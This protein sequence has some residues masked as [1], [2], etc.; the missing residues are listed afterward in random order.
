[1]LSKEELKNVPKSTQQA[2]RQR[3][4]SKSIRSEYSYY[5]E[6]KELIEAFLANKTLFNAAKGLYFIYSTLVSIIVIRLSGNQ[7]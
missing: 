5:L 6:N 4:F 2:W 3:D 1:M 7:M